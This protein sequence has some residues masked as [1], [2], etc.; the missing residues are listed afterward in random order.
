MAPF[1][2]QLDGGALDVLEGEE[3]RHA[4]DVVAA[5]F[6]LDALGGEPAGD[7]AK[8]R[9]RRQLERQLGAARV[10]AP[11]ELQ[12]QRADLARQQRAVLLARRHHQARDLGEVLDL[13]IEVRRLEGRV[14]YAPNVDHGLSRKL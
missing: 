12:Y 2:E 14:R 6:A 5:D 9:A 11:P 8:V 3:L 1:G 4:R 7:L 10:L 13:L